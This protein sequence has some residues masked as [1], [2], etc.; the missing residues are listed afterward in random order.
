MKTSKLLHLAATF[1]L[2]LGLSAGAMAQE[3][4]ESPAFRL[5]PEPIVPVTNV[6]AIE[7][8]DGYLGYDG[9]T[10]EATAFGYSFLGQT[11]GEFPGSFTLSMNCA[12][13]T[14]LPGTVSQMSG[15]SW[16]LPVYFTGLR[17]AGYA[18]SLFGTIAKGTMDWDK[19]GTSA[20][21][22]IVLSVDGGTGSWNSVAGYAI[23]T[24]TTFVDEKTG[25]TMLSGQLVFNLVSAAE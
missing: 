1:V 2:L 6:T 10:K 4:M 7:V 5:P 25:K 24:G 23:F 8:T 22:F 15:G 3:T 18:G 9:Q 17:G 11:I 14:P 20:T 21:V 12:P 16:T 13:A 19:S